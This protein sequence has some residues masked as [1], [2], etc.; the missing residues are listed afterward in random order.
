VLPLSNHRAYP[1]RLLVSCPHW[2]V[3]SQ[4]E[5]RSASD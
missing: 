5:E 1:L 2:A 4:N 3:K